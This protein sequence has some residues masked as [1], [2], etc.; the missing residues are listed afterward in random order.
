MAKPLEIDA[1]IGSE[2][3][4]SQGE[5]LSI[6]GADI[7]E[8]ESGKG[9]W[10]D[11]HGKSFTDSLGQITS[12]KK[13]FKAEDCENDRQKYYW[14]KV[15]SPFIFA[16]GFLYNNED[17]PNA[18][19]A[20]AILA[21]IHKT[22]APLKIKASV[23]GGV[24]SRGIKD[25]SYLARTKIHSVALTFT[26][27]NHATLVEPTSLK[28]SESEPLSE[29]ML[30]S[31]LPLVQD[32]VPSFIDVS[33]RITLQKISSNVKKIND[34]VKQSVGSM[35]VPVIPKSTT[36]APKNIYM[37]NAARA[38]QI[39]SNI[40]GKVQNPFTP[41]SPKLLS[42]QPIT[43]LAGNKLAQ[44]NIKTTPI[45]DWQKQNTLKIHAAKFIKNPEHLNTVKQSLQHNGVDNV[46]INK[47][48]GKIMSHVP[49]ASINKS[50]DLD[51][52]DIANIIRNIGITAAFAS[53]AHQFTQDADK[54]DKLADDKAKKEKIER[55]ATVKGL[56]SKSSIIKPAENKELDKA[57]MAGCGGGSPTSATGGAVIQKESLD[58]FKYTTCNNCG[59]DQVYHKNQ[60]KCR[61][62]NKSFS[63]KKIYSLM[64]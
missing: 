25:P 54:R 38:K 42:T 53:G 9:R 46:T 56:K 58:G 37:P 36:S 41:N 61:H 55:L 39:N 48:I 11:N 50:E 33:N 20:A 17:H 24:V 4:D 8:L 28:K 59:K 18:K 30:K 5:T 14:D 23:E 52:G 6:E 43:N 15:K 64:S 13:I 2:V 22:D 21:N 34:L 49:T 7:S 35:P 10:N 45:D 12:A 40:K 29:E 60:V 63:M 16:S 47:I 44:E 62:C 51:K 32:N 3:K 31:I 27:A 1:C 57:L 19:A 26:P